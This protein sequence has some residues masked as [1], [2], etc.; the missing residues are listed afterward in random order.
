MTK[1]THGSL[2]FSDTGATIENDSDKRRGKQNAEPL[3][4]RRQT[5]VKQLHQRQR[6]VSTTPPARRDAMC[7]LA[8]RCKVLRLP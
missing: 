8:L 2:N 5:S 3:N 1:T 4:A 6:A 7:T